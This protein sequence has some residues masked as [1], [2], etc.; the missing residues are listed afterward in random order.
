MAKILSVPKV[1]ELALY[2]TA[3]ELLY[4]LDCTG[5]RGFVDC[6]NWADKFPYRPSVSFTMAHDGKKLYVDFTVRS[7]QLR[8]VNSNNQSP[9]SQDSCVEIF[10]RPRPDGEYWNFEFNCIGAVNASHRFRKP[11]PVRLDDAE[12]ERISRFPSC[13]SQPF[14]E[15][16]G[17][18]NWNL[19][20][21]IPLDMMGIDGVGPYRME[22]NLYKCASASRAPHYLSWNPIETEGPDFHRPEFFGVIEL[23]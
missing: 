6:V 7:R 19:L 17:V 22:G 4:C 10:L 1:P 11:E 9:V 23:L 16:D 8:A 20:V 14:E 3:D 12:I 15:R 18:F 2:S 21:S 13:G 5:V